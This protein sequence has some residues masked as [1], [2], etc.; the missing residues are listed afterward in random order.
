LN[1]FIKFQVTFTLLH[2][3]IY[4]V[5]RSADMTQQHISVTIHSQRFT[6]TDLHG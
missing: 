1:Q 2:S 6:K 5:T 4:Q 3:K